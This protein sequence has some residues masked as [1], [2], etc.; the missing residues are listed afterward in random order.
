MVASLTVTTLQYRALI[1]FILTG[2][3]LRPRQ[4]T[5]INTESFWS[6]ITHALFL[7]FPRADILFVWWTVSRPGSLSPHHSDSE[8]I[9][10]QRHRCPKAT[11]NF[12]SSAKLCTA[13]HRSRHTGTG[14]KHLISASSKQ[15]NMYT[16]LSCF[17]ASFE[18]APSKTAT[19]HFKE[20]K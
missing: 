6:Y 17:P 7:F 11:F 2:H 5:M 4:T 3:L 13:P 10:A 15:S 12:S 8:Q 19:A 9:P 20:G 18:G 14:I 1:P 16:H